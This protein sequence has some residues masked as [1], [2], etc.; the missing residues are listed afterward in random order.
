MALSSSSLRLS[1]NLG[2][3]G[4]HGSPEGEIHA[5]EQRKTSHRVF[6]FF[7]G[8]GFV[9]VVFVWFGGGGVVGVVF[10]FFCLGGGC[11][12]PFFFGGGGL[13]DARVDTVSLGTCASE[14][15]LFSQVT[16]PLRHACHDTPARM[17][18]RRHAD[19]HDH[20]TGH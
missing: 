7:G 12:C 18:L 11:R 19:Y 15:G 16:G 3:P 10:V 14:E 1:D 2:P 5:A 17:N 8:G 9:G 4:L 13:S 6:F 20:A